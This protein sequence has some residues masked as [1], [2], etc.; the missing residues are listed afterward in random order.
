M[1]TCICAC[2]T[3]VAKQERI[4]HIGFE[5]FRLRLGNGA[6]KQAGSQMA[7]GIA[8]RRFNTD[9]MYLRVCLRRLRQPPW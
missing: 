5:Q 1:G 6:A 4:A 7:A 8:L 3:P 9:K 2:I